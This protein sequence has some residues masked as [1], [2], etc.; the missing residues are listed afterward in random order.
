MGR[1]R[2]L[3]GEIPG[4]G[5]GAGRRAKRESAETRRCVMAGIQIGKPRSDV[6]GGWGR[7]GRDRG[8]RV[9]GK[10]PATLLCNP[11]SNSWWGVQRERMGGLIPPAITEGRHNKSLKPTP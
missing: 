4:S 2:A 11:F 10:G 6:R 9:K 8:I 7:Q 1:T 5:A 3:M